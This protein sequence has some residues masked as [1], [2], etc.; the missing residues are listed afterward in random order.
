GE[1]FTAMMEKGYT[2]A[3]Q[4]AQYYDFIEV[5]PKPNYAPLI[6][7]QIISNTAHL[8]DIIKNMVK[9]GADLDK[10]V[11]ATGDAHYLN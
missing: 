6:E 1:V 2:D 4:K 3:K 8:E 11:V 10:P 5:Q 9:L 7:Q